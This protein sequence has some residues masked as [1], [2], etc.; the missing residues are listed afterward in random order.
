MRGVW[1][2]DVLLLVPNGVG[3]SPTQLADGCVACP[4]RSWWMCCVFVECRVLNKIEPNPNLQ[5]MGVIANPN[6]AVTPR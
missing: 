1:W 2:F 3:L 5:Q 6:L 4:Q